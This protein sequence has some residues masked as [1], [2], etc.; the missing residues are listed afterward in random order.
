MRRWLRVSTHSLSALPLS[1]WTMKR[2]LISIVLSLVAVSVAPRSSEAQPPGG[3][4][5]AETTPEGAGD[6]VVPDK[7][8]VIGPGYEPNPAAADGSG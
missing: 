8:L 7:P 3:A 6:E 1:G 5:D 4:T 2:V